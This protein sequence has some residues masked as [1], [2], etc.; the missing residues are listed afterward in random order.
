MKNKGRQNIWLIWLIWLMYNT[1]KSMKEEWKLGSMDRIWMNYNSCK[2][3]K[4]K[5]VTRLN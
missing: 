1:D 4:W 2:E 3:N 5:G